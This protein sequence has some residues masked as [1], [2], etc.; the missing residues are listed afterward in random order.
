MADSKKID[1][2]TLREA[3]KEGATPNE[4]DYSDLIDLARV[5]GKALGATD[6]DATALK[7]GTGLKL[8]GDKLAVHGDKSVTVDADGVAVKVDNKTLSVAQ[9]EGLS[10]KLKSN[11]GLIADDGAG[12]HVKTGGGL[13]AGAG[14]LAISLD[15]KGGLTT[16]TG[17]LAVAISA[18]SAG[19]M[20]DPQGALKVK[21]ATSENYIAQTG[22]GLAIT[23]DGIKSIKE[24]LEKA[25]IE[26]LN[27]AVTKTDSGAK[28]GENLKG[29]VE[30]KIAAELNTAHGKGY[31]KKRHENQLQVTHKEIPYGVNAGEVAQSVNIKEKVEV[32]TWS[33]VTLKK[34]EV[35]FIPGKNG[36]AW[37]KIVGK[38][39]VSSDGKLYLADHLKE[40]GVFNLKVLAVAVIP[41][42]TA[43]ELDIASAEITLKV[44]VSPTIK[45]VKVTPE[46]SSQVDK[47]L[48]LSYDFYPPGDDASRVEWQWKKAANEWDVGS[49]DRSWAPPNVFIGY[50][51]KAVVIP[52]SKYLEG[53]KPDV[54]S[55]NEVAI[56]GIPPVP[57]KCIRVNDHDFGPKDGF[58][59]TGFT[60]AKFTLVLDGPQASEFNW[61]ATASW[62]NVDSNGVVSFIRKGDGKT[63][64][65]TGTAKLGRGVVTYTFTLTSWFTYQGQS[66]TWANANAACNNS[67]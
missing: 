20:L 5:G 51:V 17:K 39:G 15:P 46:V 30:K 54:I 57:I 67:H 12:V 60:G 29:N 37:G 33:G 8:E 6:G 9:G 2:N 61:S 56:V 14:G 28:K 38:E 18:D 59:K 36:D 11:G 35:Y 13:V 49:R 64:T 62:V 41:N 31:A 25:S 16:A 19:L 42:N 40:V 4:K 3:F 10:V 52:R 24:A 53:Y 65:I 48:T 22:E 27:N 55:S 66:M 21:L 32:K 34:D 43:G 47:P 50:T 1:M 26:A 63:V 58:P 23:P 44:T 45:N 7:P